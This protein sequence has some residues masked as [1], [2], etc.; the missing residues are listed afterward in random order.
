MLSTS[1]G[2]SLAMHLSF[3]AAIL[4]SSCNVLAGDAQQQQQQQHV[5]QVINA[6]EAKVAYKHIENKLTPPARRHLADSEDASARDKRNQMYVYQRN[7]YHSLVFLMRLASA[8]RDVLHVLHMLRSIGRSTF[9]VLFLAH[10]TLSSSFP[11]VLPF[12][13]A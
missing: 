2:R 9:T 11:L 6:E 8:A 10:S 13:G 4:L 12:Q 7:I 3:L 5:G 1:G